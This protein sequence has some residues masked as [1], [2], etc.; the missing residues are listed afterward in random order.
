MGMLVADEPMRSRCNSC[1]IAQDVHRIPK[2]IDGEISTDA[3]P[4]LTY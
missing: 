1:V 2:M 4:V 3:Y